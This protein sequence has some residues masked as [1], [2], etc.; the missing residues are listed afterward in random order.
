MVAGMWRG[1]RRGAEI[2][3]YIILALL[4]RAAAGSGGWAICA[5]GK[6]KQ[7]DIEQKAGHGEDRAYRQRGNT[8]IFE[9]DIQRH[10]MTKQKDRLVAALLTEAT[11]ATLRDIAITQNDHRILQWVEGNVSLITVHPA[12]Q[13]PFGTERGTTVIGYY[14]TFDCSSWT[15]P[16]SLLKQVVSLK[17]RHVHLFVWMVF[18][19]K[20]RPVYLYVWMVF[21][22]KDRPVYLYVWMVFSTKDRPVYL[23]VWMVFSTKDRPVHLKV[24]MVFSTKDRP[25]HLKVWMVFSTKD[26]PVHLNVWMV[27]STKDR[28][29]HLNVW[30]VFSTKDWSDLP[31]ACVLIVFGTMDRTVV[32]RSKARLSEVIRGEVIG[33]PVLFIRGLSNQRAMNREYFLG[34]GALSL[35]ALLLLCAGWQGNGDEVKEVAFPVRMTRCT[36]CLLG[37]Q[38]FLK[39]RS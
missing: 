32:A 27:F 33:D 17:D 24:W 3:L 14:A 35:L 8:V 37:V 18:S 22:T 21:S 6:L 31:N 13:F 29:V 12:P 1:Y 15:F 26:R 28:P 7:A 39:K 10:K 34:M 2:P 30:M 25:V 19:T 5:G 23:Y 4:S 38:E 16:G 11:T 20:D 9:V 36:G